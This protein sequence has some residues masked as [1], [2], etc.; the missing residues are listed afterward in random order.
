MS[1]K[2]TSQIWYKLSE[3]KLYK[4]FK[5]LRY[6]D[7]DFIKFQKRRFKMCSVYFGLGI[8]LSF[9]K[10]HLILIG[11]LLAVCKWVTDYK[12]AESHYKNELFKKELDFS[13]FTRMLIPYLLQSNSTLYGVFNKMLNRLNDGFVKNCLENIIIDMN[14]E[15][16]S[17]KPF[18]EFA[19]KSSGT[20]ES[21]LFMTTLYD[22]QQNTDDSSVITELG[23]MASEQLFN[24]IDNI[25]EYKLNKFNM[26]PTKI[27]MLSIVI[28]FGYTGAMIVSLIKEHLLGIL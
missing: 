24:G 20:N 4:M 8:A 7:E 9:I 27:T 11:I 19:L 13:K 12:K 23:R 15:P 26:F 16:N 28:I 18:K 21:V 3:K 6:S 1:K 14:D 2:N 5:E 10:I 22:Y 17:E 25:I